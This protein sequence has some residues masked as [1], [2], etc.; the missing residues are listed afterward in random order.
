VTFRDQLL[1]G[2]RFATAGE[3]GG[4]IV[5]KLVSLGAGVEAMPEQLLL[6]EEAAAAWARERG[7]PLS[8]LVFDA[9]QS[10]GEGGGRRLQASLELAWRAA[11]A[12]AVGA[13]I[14]GDAP[15]KLVFVG[16]RPSAGAHAEPARAA[17][18]NLARTLSVEW[19]RYAITA[20]AVL[21]GT[22]TADAEV[23]ELVC[24]LISEAGEYFSGCRFELGRVAVAG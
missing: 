11:R 13:L 18:E 10:F 20:V 24:F 12:V 15:A 19:A 22:Q 14:E 23:A 4:A 7:A 21:P 2:R 16:P 8:A 5:A 17:L 1:D 3:G 6:D 9:G